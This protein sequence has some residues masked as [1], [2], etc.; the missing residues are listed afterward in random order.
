MAT[1]STQ[2]F[3]ASGLLPVM[4]VPDEAG[5]VFINDGNTY[6]LVVW[7]EEAYIGDPL[8]ITVSASAEDGTGYED[9]RVDIMPEPADLIQ[10]E[11]LE[12][13]TYF[14]PYP[15][16]R[17]GTNPTVTVSDPTRVTIAAIARMVF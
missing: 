2:Q 17:F 6:L 15:T 3:L 7:N 5:D 1:L 9:D 4:A 11:S 12:C 8:T 13:V 10:A 16:K 14:G